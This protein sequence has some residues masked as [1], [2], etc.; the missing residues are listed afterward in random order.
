MRWMHFAKRLWMS[1]KWSV[2]NLFWLA[3]LLFLLPLR[4][5]VAAILAACIHELGHYIAVCLC[6]GNIRSFHLGVSGAVM[7]ASG[8]TGWKEILCL[9]AGPL[10]GLLPLLLCK[11]LPTLALCGLIQTLYNLIPIYP[12]DGGKLL[13]RTIQVCGG[14][15]RLYRAIEYSFLLVFGIVCIYLYL[16]FGISILFFMGP[17]IFRKTPCKHIMD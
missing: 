12:L 3:I 10:A 11:I 15:D 4:W 16:R 7:C 14:S 8:I 6:G 17:F 5:L 1:D 9:L 2:L 13:H